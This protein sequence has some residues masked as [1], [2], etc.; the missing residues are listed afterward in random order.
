[1]LWGKKKG[2]SKVR[3]LTGFV[4]LCKKNLRMVGNRGR[5]VGSGMD[6]GACT[7]IFT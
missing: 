6:L 2:K 5:L 1:M 4:D 3:K 7:G